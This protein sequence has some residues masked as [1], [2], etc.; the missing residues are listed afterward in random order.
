MYLNSSISIKNVIAF[1]VI[2]T[3]IKYN[4]KL[5]YSI[6]IWIT[7][8]L[9]YLYVYWWNNKFYESNNNLYTLVEYNA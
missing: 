1:Q 6:A 3:N 5:V 2:R 7:R 8:W 4:K 9:G